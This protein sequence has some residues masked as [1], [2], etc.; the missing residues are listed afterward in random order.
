MSQRLWERRSRDDDFGTVRLGTGVQKLAI[1]LIPP[2][3]KPVEDL[4][5]L[6]SGALRRFV[7]AHSTVSKLPVAVA[8]QSFARIQ[9]TGDPMAVRD[10]VRAMVAQ[11]AVFHSPDD[12][13]VMVCAGEEW[14][15][16]WDWVKWLPRAASRGDR[17]R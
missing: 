11:M 3:S 14:M 9:L 16:Q 10:L 2:D 7:R 1:Q 17:R 12:M 6:S 8:L 5:A 4:D 13:R 15:A